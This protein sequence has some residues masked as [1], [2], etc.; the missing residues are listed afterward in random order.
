MRTI[1]I[2]CLLTLCLSIPCRGQEGKMFTTDKEL[3]SSM[4][5]KIYQDKDGI[6]W[7][8]TEDGLNRYDGAKFTVYRNEKNNPHSLLGN[9]VRTLFE[10]S[11]GRFFVGSLNGLQ[12]YD[13]ATDQFTT[14]LMRFPDGNSVA[15]NISTMLERKNGSILIG[16]S[17]HSLFELEQQGDTIKAKQ[18]NDLV[19]S[20]LITCLYEDRKE[21]L[22]VATSN[23]GIFRIDPNGQVKQYIKEN[24][25][26][27]NTISSICEDKNGQLYIGSLKRGLFAY[28]PQSDSFSPIT[29]APKSELP[30]KILYPSAHNEIYIGT[31]GEGMKT[32]DIQEKK[33]KETNF[34]TTLFDLK[35]AKIHSIL[36]D[37]MGNLWLGF[38]QK[39]VMLMPAMT[40]QFNYI[41]YKSSMHDIIGSG[42][43]MSVCKDH[44]GILWVGT[45]NDGI[46]GISPDGTL[47]AHFA[48]TG[49]PHSVPATIMSLFEDSNHNLW[50]GSYMNGMAKLNTQT[51]H[52]E[53]INLLDEK[54]VP[55][56]SVYS[57]AE[58]NR[59]TLWIGTMGA[60]LYSMD[61]TT[62]KVTNCSTPKDEKDWNQTNMLHNSWINSLLH[63]SDD[64]LYIGTYDG[65]GCLDTRK[66]DF[67]S[68][69]KERRTLSGDVVYALCESRNGRVWIGTAKGL[70]SLDPKT[71]QI[72]EYTIEDGLP[73]D[74]ICGI[75]ED[76]N[77][78][79]WIST[80]Y[81]ISRFNPDA[82]SFIN[83]H[84]SDGLQGNEFSKGAAF[85]SKEGEFIFGGTNG[86]TCFD[87]ARISNPNKQP[88]IR[89]T[90]F[91]IHDKTVKKGMKS[92]GKD[93]VETAVMDA[94]HFHLSHKDNS[95][96]IEFSVMEFYSPER[97]TYMYAFNNSSNWV[98]LRPG[99]NRISFSDLA[100]GTYRFMVK[101]KDYASYSNTKEI[102]ITISPAWYASTWAWVVYALLAT[103][104]VYVVIMQIRHRIRAKREIM[105][106]IHTEQINE[107][108]LQFF[109]NISHEIR[110]PM[111]LII[112]PLQKLIATDKDNE[113]QKTYYTI[114][115][116]AERILRLVNQLMD[117]RKI[118]KGQMQLKFQ[119]TDIVSLI[120]DLYSTFE[121]QAKSKHIAFSFQP[122]VQEQ[123]L[124]IDPKH[125]DKVIMNILSNAFKFTPENGE[126]N[127]FLHTGENPGA[128]E[129]PLRH[130]LEI[131]VEDS[132][133][134]ISP[135]EMG[136]IFERFYQIRNSHN[137]SNVG[138]GIG[139]HLSRSLVELHHGTIQAENND[140]KTG[141]R[142]IIRLP[143]GKAHLKPEEIEEEAQKFVTP[144][145]TAATLPAQPA[146]DEETGKVRS[147]TKNQ[148]LVVEDDEEIRNYI[149]H[150]L[151]ANFHMQ[152]CTNGKDALNLILKKVPDLIISDIMMPEMDGLTLCR[153]IKQNV[154]VN[155]I[156]VILLT[157][158]SREED[159]LEGLKTG[160][161]AYIVKPFNIEI[162]RKT[163]Q[164]LI[165]SREVLR[166]SF[167]GNQKQ[168]D[169]LQKL[170]VQSPDEKLLERVMKIINANLGNPELNVE[171]IANS[172][173]ISR[174]HLHRKLKELTNQSTRDLIRNVRLQQ[175]AA[176]LTDKR[177]NITDVALLTGFQNTTYF[178][179]A[180]K[181]LY[182]V[183][184]TAYMEQ[185]LN[186]SETNSE[187]QGG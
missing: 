61:I 88:E 178:S 146:P 45:D 17:G 173:G 15:P 18:I 60:G 184:P 170:E 71:G 16:T 168:S 34:S 63:T 118:D 11:R 50:L 13:R 68:P 167:S 122:E 127:I 121:Q 161:D 74:L 154:T 35:R 105:E 144:V 108:K 55:V 79:L 27:L 81:G 112:S 149:C 87:P 169:K 70:K 40:N 135:A 137:N 148:V 25:V 159:N 62:G 76:A 89:I 102:I 120:H 153:K 157:A 123:K 176:L 131:V 53:Y 30:V 179:T 93:I 187:E 52:C 73:S 166:N 165:K 104:V 100:P 117:I 9:H 85:A 82:R 69:L 130:Y 141:T 2:L 28:Q 4:I 162:L 19:A 5:N 109:I 138:T 152:A 37:K 90:D 126:I 64:R 43:V 39:G 155:H 29:Y 32:Y 59:K 77:G 99:I 24:S 147:R 96:S 132:G 177:R 22:W 181:E 143:L 41:G 129:S 103:A 51:G 145:H 156:P 183:T 23:N 57:F 94:E 115:R 56:E 158:K 48:P 10:D 33:I 12:M 142:F 3:S 47:K 46:Y 164:N 163:A 42:C 98:S 175:A 101:A 128:Q 72:N 116:N 95:F 44:A 110:T 92:G 134:G 136:R 114:Y 140:G 38:F 8:A 36:K 174:V 180:F 54:S 133:I 151:A 107:A 113:R 67:V 125:F 160:A 75:K 119:E 66:M 111:S 84:A 150:E 97:I 139:L 26:A 14:I 83:F 80:N 171:M 49:T 78:Y 31:D 21:N 172:A 86:I 6:I 7:I 65:L 124:W 186:T 20:S 91:Y 185:Q 106:H 182:G 58:D 1:F